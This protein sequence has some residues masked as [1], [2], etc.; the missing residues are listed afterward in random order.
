MCANTGNA[1]DAG[2]PRGRRME[3]QRLCLTLKIVLLSQ[4]CHF[5][6]RTGCV[7]LQLL[8][9]IPTTSSSS[10]DC[11]CCCCCAADSDATV[12]ASDSLR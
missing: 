6:P 1:V 5:F 8:R 9:Y 3:H 11:C 2:E 12:I 7:L 10:T 4:A